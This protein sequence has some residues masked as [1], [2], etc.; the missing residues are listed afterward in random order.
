MPVNQYMQ[1]YGVLFTQTYF[2][3]R[4]PYNYVKEIILKMAKNL[5]NKDYNKVAYHSRALD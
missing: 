3:E 1:L 4:V 2:F 5:Y